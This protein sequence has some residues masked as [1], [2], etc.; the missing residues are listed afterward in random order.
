M[1]LSSPTIVF[2]AVLTIVV[3]S[4]DSKRLAMSA[5]MMRLSCAPLMLSFVIRRSL[6]NFLTDYIITARTFIAQSDRLHGM[7]KRPPRFG[8][9]ASGRQFRLVNRKNSAYNKKEPL[10]TDF[11][12]GFRKNPE[13]RII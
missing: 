7:T 8:P 10:T 11:I 3:S 6:K 5:M 13:R 2:M 1:P 12:G 4:A 9:N